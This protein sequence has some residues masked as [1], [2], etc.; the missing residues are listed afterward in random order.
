MEQ[1][2]GENGRSRRASREHGPC[3]DHL[4]AGAG[5]PPHCPSCGAA[6]PVP[7]PRARV[8]RG[9]LALL[10]EAGDLL[11]GVLE[12]DH[13]AALAAQLAVPRLGRWCA[14]YLAGSPR[15]D[16]V[17]SVRLA[18]AWHAVESRNAELADRLGALPPPLGPLSGPAPWAPLPEAWVF[19]L[20]VGARWH[21]ALLLARH[22]SAPPEAVDGA[23]GAEA[24]AASTELI[25]SVARRVAVALDTARRYGRAVHTNRV[26]QRGL[27]PA[28]HGV[29][30]P[31]LDTR[32]V[33]EPAGEGAE[34]GG[35]FYDM[36][37]CGDGR[38]AFA[39]GD[40]C[41]SG[42][43]AG[44]LSGLARHAVRILGRDRLGPA[45]VLER[46]NRVLMDETEQD[47]GRFLS[48]LYGEVERTAD[49]GATLVTAS[50]G[51]PPVL[52]LGVD[53]TVREATVPQLLLGIRE[54]ER[55]QQERVRL[56]PGEVLLAVTD[57][58][59]ERRN[60]TRALDDGDGL[61]RI[62]AGCVGLTAAGVA[63]RV[64]GAVHGFA[65]EPPDDDVAILVLRAGGGP[66]GA[67]IGSL[68]G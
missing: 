66:G 23:D 20:M 34:V 41:G 65:P 45:G 31:G 30:V 67:D 9:R 19:P 29:A 51:H 47:H 46:L 50:G 26:L 36:F 8:E 59:T 52:V 68:S 38:W 11:A 44:A 5:T 63:E 7:G 49:G 4:D 13:V 62:L 1:L 2:V 27:L 33:Y 28:L 39:L 16:H 40:V 58:V 21:G 12:E 14:V 64:R 56:A 35:D 10:L 48:L 55:Y 18:C 6:V 3:T 17:P 57:G 43:E 61:A 54:E 37:P 60:G 32:V 22:P 24:A 42:P 15:P 53:G 25:E